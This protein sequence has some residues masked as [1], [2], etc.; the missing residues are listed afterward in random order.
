[1][2]LAEPA[3]QRSGL[4][5]LAR[6]VTAAAYAA[7]GVPVDECVFL[8]RGSL[9]KT[10]SGKLQRYRCREIALSDDLRIAARIAA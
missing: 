2:V 5:P 10:P 6:E 3:S 4:R 1:M 9:P 7:A 8:H